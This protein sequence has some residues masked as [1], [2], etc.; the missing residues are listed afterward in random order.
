MI[1]PTI[2]Q[3]RLADLIERVPKFEKD[4]PAWTKEFE[5]FL[6]VQCSESQ[7]QKALELYALHVENMTENAGE[8]L[9]G[10]RNG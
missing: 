7:G 2:F 4:D 9:H 1:S 10:Q 6:F 3:E 5:A 8:F